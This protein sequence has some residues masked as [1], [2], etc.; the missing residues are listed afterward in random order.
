MKNKIS[1]VTDEIRE[2]WNDQMWWRHRIGARVISPFHTK[3]HPTRKG[4]VY[5]TDEDW[6]ILVVLDACR[7][8]L[9]ESVVDTGIF[10][11]YKRV[12]S[13]GSRTPE[14]A[15]QN[16]Q[17]H[18]LGD[19]VYISSNGWVST[20]LDDTFYKLVEVWQ[21]T[22]GPPRPEDITEAALS[23]H[24]EFPNK[25]LIVHYLQPHR[26]FLESDIGFDKSFSDNP[27]QALG[28]GD[29]DVE[30][31]WALYQ[32]NLEAVFDEAYE[33]A[34][35]LPG[36]AVMTA[37]HG[38]LLGERTYPLPIRL[39]GHP[40]GVRHPGLVEVPWA[41]IESGERPQILNEGI[42]ETTADDGESVKNH[43]E[44]LGYV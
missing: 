40:E 28:N 14:W 12:T 9:F 22:D 11:S 5:V 17:S 1:Y 24:D 27:W 15:R 36:R 2:N 44:A 26:P 37:D 31:I 34:S 32:Q 21:E 8:D 38:N 29:T 13:P 4:S 19:T 23:A 3:I 10:D 41:V 20:V 33:L 43:L 35:D 16:F 7:A 18:D 30:T 25:R 6:D 39:Y 42:T